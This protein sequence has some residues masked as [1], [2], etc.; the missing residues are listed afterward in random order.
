MH[1][2]CL[3]VQRA[4]AISGSRG[5]PK[6]DVFEGELCAPVSLD[7]V[8]DIIST[9]VSKVVVAVSHFVRLSAFIVLHSML[10]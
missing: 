6:T 9:M 2:I 10:Y 5:C 8:C 3:I 4:A 7:V 1:Q